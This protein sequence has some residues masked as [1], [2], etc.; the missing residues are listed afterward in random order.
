MTINETIER[1][2]ALAHKKKS[3]QPLTAEEEQEKKELYKIYLGF[4]RGQVKQNLD[5]I[6]F[7]DTPPSSKS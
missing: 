3:G 4:I 2:N 1:I 5:S 7:V 6:E